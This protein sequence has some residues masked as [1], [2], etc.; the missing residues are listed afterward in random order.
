MPIHPSLEKLLSVQVVDSQIIFLRE[1]LRQRPREL[2]DDR[3]RVASARAAVDDVKAK[4]K[5]TK[6]ASD[7]RDLEVKRLEGEIN[8]ANIA[9]NTAK[10]NQ[11]YTIFKEQIAR[12]TTQKSGV[13]DEVLERLTAIDDLEALQ[14]E[15][16]GRLAE[17]ETT[18]RKKEAE[19][20]E[21]IKGMQTEVDRHLAKRAELIQGLDPEHLR[22]YDRV[23]ER[24][25][26]F[27]ISRVESSVCHGCYMAVTSQDQNLILQGQL[28]QCKSCSRLLYLDG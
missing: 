20:N 11:E 6:L 18:L 15:R 9:L 2:E 27:A 12:L 1:S 28:V 5:A 10:T 13:E 8:K 14:K 4:I 7:Q 23:L 19:L 25:N 17:V 26:N 3:R 16:Q 24:H 21:L 22:L